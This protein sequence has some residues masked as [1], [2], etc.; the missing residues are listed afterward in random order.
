MAGIYSTCVF[1][2]GLSEGLRLA[3]NT[4]NVEACMQDEHST[5]VTR[6]FRKFQVQAA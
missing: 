6:E 1:V 3:D 5:H 4:P 2:L